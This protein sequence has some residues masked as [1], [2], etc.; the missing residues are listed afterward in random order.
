MLKIGVTT[1]AEQQGDEVLKVTFWI[2]FQRTLHH[3]SLYCCRCPPSLIV[4]LS[5]DSDL[6]KLQFHKSLCTVTPHDLS[7]LVYIRMKRPS[8]WPVS[9]PCL[10]ATKIPFF[11]P[12]T[13]P[14]LFLSHSIREL[15]PGTDSSPILW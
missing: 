11:S 15:Y 4:S 5:G 6:A 14:V 7:R 9:V 1:Y 8:S 3:K 13:H 12:N 10:S 2:F